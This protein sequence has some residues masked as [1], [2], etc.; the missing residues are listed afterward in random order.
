[1]PLVLRG[2]VFLQQGGFPL[3][4]V[5]SDFLTLGLGE[6]QW[7]SGRGGGPSGST[8]IGM[9]VYDLGEEEARRYD[10]REVGHS[11]SR[12]AG[13]GTHAPPMTLETRV[14]VV[15]LQPTGG[16]GRTPRVLGRQLPPP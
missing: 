1:M 9:N 12:S 2:E 5:H 3:R 14:D 6:L 16:G 13:Y 11:M 4:P 8:R 10:G 7:Q 15:G